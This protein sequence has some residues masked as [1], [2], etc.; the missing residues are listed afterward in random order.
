MGPFIIL[1]HPAHELHVVHGGGDFSWLP[2][3]AAVCF[4]VQKYLSIHKMLFD[5][6]LLLLQPLLKVIDP[7]PALSE[8]AVLFLQCI[9]VMEGLLLTVNN[10]PQPVDLSLDAKVPKGIEGSLNVGVKGVLEG[11]E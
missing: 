7:S 5:V 9:A 2:V 11:P 1:G 3:D 10:S 6:G 8:L 4:Q